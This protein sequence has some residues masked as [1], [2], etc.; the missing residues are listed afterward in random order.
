M[1]GG[2]IYK[3]HGYLWRVV[4]WYFPKRVFSICGNLNGACT[5]G[6]QRE[7]APNGR[8]SGKAKPS[9]VAWSGY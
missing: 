4:L 7:M 5:A 1:C 6:L 8:S 2:Q 3:Q 9:I